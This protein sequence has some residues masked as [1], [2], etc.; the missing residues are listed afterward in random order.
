MYMYVYWSVIYSMLNVEPGDVNITDVTCNA[1]NMINQCTVIWNVSV[2]CATCVC[3]YI[4]GL[5]L[6]VIRTVWVLAPMCI[7]LCV[8][9]YIYDML[10]YVCTCKSPDSCFYN[11][12]IN[13]WNM[14]IIMYPCMYKHCFSSN[15]RFACW[16]YIRT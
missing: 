8:H 2:W 16:Q 13:N 7:H 5:C 4:T 1:L 14:Y 10:L 9:K 12:N 11:Q 15:F 3:V 6:Y